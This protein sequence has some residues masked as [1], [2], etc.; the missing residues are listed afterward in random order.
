ME[1]IF[2][3]IH[4]NAM[5]MIN[6][7]LSKCSRSRPV[8]LTIESNV[9]LS[10]L[11]HWRASQDAA[12]QIGL[13]ML[14]CPGTPI[15]ESPRP[16]CVLSPP[17]SP[18]EILTRKL[19]RNEE[20]GT[21]DIFAAGD[22]TSRIKEADTDDV[23]RMG[24]VMVHSSTPIPSIAS[25]GT[26]LAYLASPSL[27]SDDNSSEDNHQAFSAIVAIRGENNYSMHRNSEMLRQ[28]TAFTFFPSLRRQ[29]VFEDSPASST[30]DKENSY[31]SEATTLPVLT[32]LTV[33]HADSLFHSVKDELHKLW[34]TTGRR[35]SGENRS[36]DSSTHIARME[37]K[38]DDKMLWMEGLV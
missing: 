37:C 35:L 16:G 15:I 13:A 30:Y 23:F 24:D 14:T 34:A 25:T 8:S 12:H 18:W 5:E 17:L 26:E 21:D 1:P 32:D 29:S 9:S 7:E 36:A 10:K 2:S 19:L 4:S 38:S 20:I 31:G 3:S 11:Q 27:L 33:S 6:L 28:S 22:A